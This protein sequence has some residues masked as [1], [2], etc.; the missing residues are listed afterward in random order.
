MELSC[1]PNE[2][3]RGGDTFAAKENAYQAALTMREA[4]TGR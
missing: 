1:V 4:K 3:G 2:L